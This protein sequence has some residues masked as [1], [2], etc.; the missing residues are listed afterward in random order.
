M[1]TSLHNMTCMPTSKQTS[2]Q[3]NRQTK[4]MY[5]CMQTCIRI[6]T[7]INAHMHVCK[8]TNKHASGNTYLCA[9]RRRQSDMLT[10]VHAC[11][12]AYMHSY[13]HSS[14]PACMHVLTY[15]PTYMHY[16]VSADG[17]SRPLSDLCTH[18]RVDTHL[19]FAE[20]YMTLPHSQ[21]HADPHTHMHT[22]VP[23]A[24]GPL[25]PPDSAPVASGGL[26]SQVRACRV[27]RSQEV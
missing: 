22:S 6:R 14:M 19:K 18:V 8:H 21:A 17:H 12:R 13:V 20:S 10:Y 15:V 2:K 27:G 3:L 25:S 26:A 1:H 9:Q 24:C 23:A 4:K 11:I 7:N 16:T 5:G